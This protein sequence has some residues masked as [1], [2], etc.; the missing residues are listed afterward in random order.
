MTIDAAHF[1]DLVRYTDWANRRVLDALPA[2]EAHAEVYAQALDL[3]SHVLRSQVLWLQRV[4]GAVD[5]AFPFWH[6]DTLDQCRQRNATSTADWTTHLASCTSANFEQGIAYTNSRG[7]S[8]I[9]TLR[10]I[11]THV[12]N[13]GTHHRGQVLRLLRQQGQTPP[14]LDYIVFARS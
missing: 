5:P 9:S 10:Q 11:V 3:M 4:A 13:H 14:A 7:E 6:R 2:L 12:V 8:F 1:L